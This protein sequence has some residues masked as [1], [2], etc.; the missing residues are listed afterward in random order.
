M[1]KIGQNFQF[2]LKSQLHLSFGIFFEI[3]DCHHFYVAEFWMIDALCLTFYDL[4]IKIH[5][6]EGAIPWFFTNHWRWFCDSLLRFLQSHGFLLYRRTWLKNRP[7]FE[8]VLWSLL[9]M[10]RM[11][12]I[13]ESSIRKEK[14]E[15]FLFPVHCH[16]EWYRCISKNIHTFPKAPSP[17]FRSK[18]KFSL[19]KT[20]KP[21]VATK[22]TTLSYLGL[23]IPRFSKLS[24]TWTV[25]LE[26]TSFTSCSDN[27]LEKAVLWRFRYMMNKMTRN[28]KTT[29]TTD[30]IMMRVTNWNGGGSVSFC[31][32][33]RVKDKN[34]VDIPVRKSLGV[35]INVE[36]NRVDISLKDALR[37]PR[38]QVELL[39]E[40]LD[41]DG[42]LG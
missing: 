21:S 9:F 28:I 29:Q 15:Q 10:K 6:I 22:L 20:V 8:K 38:K 18:T 37:S 13:Y 27:V 35:D 17:R 33:E 31:C 14:T 23:V 36:I 11:N 39:K 41:N 5:L 19:E 26:W 4:K 42:S 2:S 12:D 32:P 1:I 30:P 25:R 7:T 3:F 40:L 24:L 16:F 34:K